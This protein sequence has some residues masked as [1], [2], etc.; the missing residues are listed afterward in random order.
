MLC[1]IKGTRSFDSVKLDERNRFSFSLDSV[2]E[3]LHHFDHDPELQYVYLEGGDSLVIRLNTLYFDESL[4]FSGTG[5]EINNFLLERYLKHEDESGLIRSLYRLEPERFGKHIDSLIDTGLRAFTELEKEGTLSEKEEKIAR[6]SIV[7]HYNT[8]KEEY[9]FKHKRL[10]GQ[11]AIGNLP[12]NFYGYRKAL[13]RNDKD[14]T[15]LL[16]YYQF[17]INHVGN[18]SY[19]SCSEGCDIEDGVAQNPLHFNKHMLDVIDS[20]I[21]ERELRDN[22][23]RHV[24]FDYLLRAHDSEADNEIF[25][26]D[27]HRLSDNNRHMKEIEA[28]YEGIRNIQPNSR[29]PEVMVSDVNGKSVSLKRD[30]KGQ[31]EQDRF[32]FLVRYQSK[33]F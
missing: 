5:E 33:P 4:I 32:L 15:Y 24:A 30:C 21:E 12:E 2:S 3:G 23:F 31:T 22:L 11:N 16:P 10:T 14:L 8:Y 26:D 6:A 25:I 17:M 13:E 29:I 18:L 28:L 7:Y 19:M 20:L 1:Y 27:F 9:P